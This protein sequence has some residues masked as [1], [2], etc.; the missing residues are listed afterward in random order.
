MGHK[1]LLVG[2]I[3]PPIGGVGI[4]LTRLMEHLT[5]KNIPFS[6]IYLNK[7]FIPKIIW[8]MLHHKLLHLH[9]SNPHI[10]FLF[11]LLGKILSCKVIITY[12]GDLGRFSSFKNRFDYLSIKYCDYPIV[13]N[14]NSLTKAKELNKNAI[15]VSAFI[16]PSQTYIDNNIY[17]IILNFVS[18]FEFSFCTNAYTTTIDKN[19]IEVYGITNICKIF[20]QKEK[21]ALVLSDPSGDY[22]RFFNKNK[23]GITQNI[24]IVNYPHYFMTVLDLCDAYIRATSTDGDSISVNEALYLKKQVVASDCTSRPDGVVLY[25]V[26]DWEDFNNKLEEVAFNQISKS[27]LSIPNGADELVALY[28]M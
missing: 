22:T 16:P 3:P 25:K 2:K 27:P 11:A 13:L 26:G 12:H 24:L 9:T 4:H 14:E 23:I 17:N 1:I 10:R 7:Y 5:D 6:Y 18:Y 20:Q 28:R 15:K 8:A 19:G 21:W